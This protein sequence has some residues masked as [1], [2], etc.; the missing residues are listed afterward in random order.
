MASGTITLKRTGSGYLNGRIQWESVSNGT[1]KNTSTVTAT[2]QIQRGAQNTTTGT[3]K[4]AFT[5]GGASQNISQFM[6]LPSNTWVTVKTVTVTV[7]H[8]ASG[9]GSCYLYAKIDGPSGTSMGGTSVSGSETVQLDKITRFATIL[10]GEDFT[11][12]GNPTITYSNPAGDSVESLQVCI[13]LDGSKDDVPYK[14]IPKTGKSY[15]FS[16]TEDE[17]NTLRSAAPNSNTLSVKFYIKTVLGGT[18][19][20]SSAPATMS[21]V[22]A[23]PTVSI[24]VVDANSDTVALTGNNKVLVALHSTANVTVSATAN[25]CATIPSGG[26]KIVHGDSILTG[27]GELSPV[28]NKPITFTV[29]DS[30]G[31]SVKGGV[32][33][34]LV[35]YFDPTIAIENAMPSASGEMTLNATGKVFDGSFGKTQNSFSMKYRYRAGSGEYTDWIPFDSATLDG[36]YY[37][38]TAAVTG[39]DYQARY[40]FQAVVYD[41]LHLD[42]VLSEVKRFIAEPVFF[43]SKDA[44]QFNV[45]VAMPKNGI[46]VTGNKAITLEDANYAIANGWYRI[47]GTTTN[48]ISVAAIM[49]VESTTESNVVQTA[50]AGGYSNQYYL[51]QQR[52]CHNGVWGAWEWVNPPMLLGTEYRTT[53]RH[54]GK[55]VYVSRLSVG[56]MGNNSDISAQL[57]ATPTEIVELTGLAVNGNI[58]EKLPLITTSGTIG[59]TIRKAGTKSI[60]VRTFGDY[61]GYTA[62]A[63]VKY[64]KD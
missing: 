32:V 23:N 12:E 2:L 58:V 52:Y 20:R 30:R 6:E 19:G 46:G 27:S 28:V 10:S 56:A 1:Q 16:L 13:S 15:T 48:G 39:L 25:K 9:V 45:P 22:N 5:V 55:S 33:G 43:W 51:I 61:T 34:T 57:Q 54:K 53:E 18:T 44:F 8:N 17:R 40:T 14:D 35:P 47:T 59:A 62:I 3:F 4:G 49:R 29:T 60:A 41:S 63:T 24:S 64:T 42:G 26:I 11:D 21:I 31:N 36:N 38:A 37:V 7:S 50:F